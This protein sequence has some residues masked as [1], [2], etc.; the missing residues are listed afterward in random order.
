[1]LIAAL[2][3]LSLDVQV[4]P[5]GARIAVRGSE[6]AERGLLRQ[7]G[8]LRDF[9]QCDALEPCLTCERASPGPPAT[10]STRRSPGRVA[11]KRRLT[12]V[13][14]RVPPRDSECTSN[15]IEA[16]ASD[17][18]VAMGERSRSRTARFSVRNQPESSYLLP[19]VN[20]TGVE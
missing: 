16:I 9:L 15:G 1:M 13:Q 6:S 20:D 17:A 19:T 10:P 5:A 18:P 11:V 2:I 12:R 7:P 3:R 8:R 14:G 4:N